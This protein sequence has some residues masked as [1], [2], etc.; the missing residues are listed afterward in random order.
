[1][2]EPNP[3]EGINKKPLDAAQ[4]N[5][6]KD[7]MQRAIK[8]WNTGVI[9]QCLDMGA[10]AQPLLAAAIE[11]KDFNLVMLAFEKGATV[12]GHDG[13]IMHLAYSCFD[14]SIVMYLTTTHRVPVD[15][16]GAN[17]KTAAER[18]LDDQ[19]PS[20]LRHLISFGAD[21]KKHAND[22]FSLG[23]IKSDAGLIE[24]AHQQGVDVNAALVP[25]KGTARTTGLQV[26]CARSFHENNLF[27]ALQRAGVDPDLHLDGEEPPIIAVLR[28]TPERFSDGYDKFISK[29]L[30][31]GANVN[32]VNSKGETALLVATEKKEDSLCE[33]LLSKG[34]D[35]LIASR[36]G[37]TAFDW[38]SE[39]FL[40]AYMKKVQEL[41]VYKLSIEDVDLTTE[42]ALRPLNPIRFEANDKL[43]KPEK[44]EGLA[45]AKTADAKPKL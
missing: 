27:D 16:L 24:W 35:P 26:L 14:P 2:T 13:S 7:V 41:Y 40:P 34:A 23:I 28:R 38:V 39:K 22:V 29:L 20:V 37:K 18:A 25:G 15:Q 21:M 31:M 3:T 42:T 5:V 45:P 43:R 12:Q 9:S 11:H 36:E 8:A 1:M 4:K 19:K 30:E 32:A 17:G 6:M 10:D 33:L 44:D